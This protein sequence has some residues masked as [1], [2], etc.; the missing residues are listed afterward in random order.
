MAERTR[1]RPHADPDVLELPMV[2]AM[3][4]VTYN[5]HAVE[6]DKF[7]GELMMRTAELPELREIQSG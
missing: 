5:F 7:T 2:R 3:N 4:V 6:W 1:Y